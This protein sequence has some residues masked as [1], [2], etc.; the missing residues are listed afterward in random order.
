MSRAIKLQAEGIANDSNPKIMPGG[1]GRTSENS[2]IGTTHA[3]A[4]PTKTTSF[5]ICA[6][7]MPE[8]PQFLEACRN[9]RPAFVARVLPQTLSPF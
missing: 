2:N 5:I 1:K 7:V 6:M 3:H 4:T 9:V 8:F